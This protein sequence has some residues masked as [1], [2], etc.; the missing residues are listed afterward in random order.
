MPKPYSEEI[1]SAWANKIKQQMDSGLSIA[2]WCLLNEVAI[3]QFYYW[4]S[5]LFPRQLNRNSF[6]ELRESATG[7]SVE[8]KGLSVRIEKSFDSVTLK[9]FLSLLRDL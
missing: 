8:C 3:H 6:T 5:K 4:K 7:I 1:R 2:R 9:Q